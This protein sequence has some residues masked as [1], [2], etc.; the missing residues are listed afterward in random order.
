[1]PIARRARRVGVGRQQRRELDESL[2]A[3]EVALERGAHRIASVGRAGGLLAAL[4]QMRVVQG[5]HERRILRREFQHALDHKLK[6]ALGVPMVPGEDAVVDRPVLEL[7]PRGAEKSAHRVPAEAGQLAEAQ[8]SGAPPS[9]LWPTSPVVF[10]LEITSS[11]SFPPAGSACETCEPI[12]T[13]RRPV[14]SEQ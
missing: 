14:S 9:S 8:P 10:V 5:D 3:D 11:T 6:E 12:V 2:G 4:A 13:T 7:P 1:M